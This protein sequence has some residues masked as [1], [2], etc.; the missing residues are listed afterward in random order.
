MSKG[1]KDVRI[2]EV[3]DGRTHSGALVFADTSAQLK[4]YSATSKDT[5]KRESQVVFVS[6]WKTKLTQC[7]VLERE[8]R[9]LSRNL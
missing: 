5:E 7:I 9:N 3:L 8:H 4:K 6:W 2:A 1:E